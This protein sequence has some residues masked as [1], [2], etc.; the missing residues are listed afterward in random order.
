MEDFTTRSDVDALEWTQSIRKIRPGNKLKICGTSSI[1]IVTRTNKTASLI[2][3]LPIIGQYSVEVWDPE[4][5]CVSVV[6]T[7]MILE[8][9][10]PLFQEVVFQCEE[11]AFVHGEYRVLHTRGTQELR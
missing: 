8:I 2:G 1:V 6:H 5:K 10:L 11:E 4:T 9:K 7:D 3:P